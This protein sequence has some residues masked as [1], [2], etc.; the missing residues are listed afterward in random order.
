MIKYRFKVFKFNFVY[1]FYVIFLI[2]E[3]LGSL[4][5]DP[6]SLLILRVA[7]KWFCK[8]GFFFLVLQPKKKWVYKA[9]LLLLKPHPFICQRSFISKKVGNRR[10]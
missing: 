4:K 2:L 7:E 1:A 9:E 10:N 8:L 5:V 3:T 6:V